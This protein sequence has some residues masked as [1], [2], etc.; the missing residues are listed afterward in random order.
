MKATL[1]TVNAD[2][3]AGARNLAVHII[4]VGVSVA[5]VLNP[6][7]ARLAI[8]LRHATA[9][10]LLAL[11]LCLATIVA[12]AAMHIRTGRRRYFVLAVAGIAAIPFV[13]V[14]A[15][16]AVSW[17]VARYHEKWIGVSISGVYEPDERLGWH[18][19]PNTVGRHVVAGVYDA[20]YGMDALGRRKMPPPAAGRPT[21]HVFGSS[22]TFSDGVNDDET[23][24]YIL[25]EAHRNRFNVLNYSVSGYGLDQVVLRL[26]LSKDAIRPGDVVMIAATSPMFEWN[27]LDRSFPCGFKVW[28]TEH[29]IGKYPLLE[30][31]GWHF[32]DV[33]EE[34]G[35]IE[36]LLLN[37][38]DLPL[39][40]LYKR[41]RQESLRPRLIA[42]A[43]HLFRRARE[44]AAVRGA[45]FVVV[46]LAT[47][48]ECQVGKLTFSIDGLRARTVSML[49][50]CAEMA[51]AVDRLSFKN[52]GHYTVEGNRWMAGVLDKIVSKEVPSWN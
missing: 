29:P 43:D 14:V 18:L 45:R 42:H 16:L 17:V 2:T 27:L 21:L 28:Q 32:Y 50:Y 38:P 3:G 52:D 30:E 12:L 37:S 5:V 33:R 6:L 26:E 40:N 20:R 7:T 49:P 41:M 31:D 9:G 22:F 23:A 25:A 10:Y 15:E 4:I 11:D 44:V 8:E 46:M 13:M 36:A 34:C 1:P 24:L 48:F 47:P 51:N 39:G 35:F 19:I